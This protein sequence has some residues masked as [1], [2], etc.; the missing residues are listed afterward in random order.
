MIYSSAKWV[1]KNKKAKLFITLLG[2][3]SVTIGSFLIGSTIGGLLLVS[4]I[5][6]EVF[7]VYSISVVTEEARM[8]IESN[9]NEI[10]QIGRAHV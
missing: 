6:M 5:L 10:S 8:E 7:N 4:G 1:G 9:R 2:A 3:G